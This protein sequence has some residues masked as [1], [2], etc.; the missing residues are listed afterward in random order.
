MLTLARF[1]TSFM[2]IMFFGLFRFGDTSSFLPPTTIVNP[3]STFYSCAVCIFGAFVLAKR[4]IVVSSGIVSPILAFFIILPEA[5]SFS[6]D[7]FG[8]VSVLKKNF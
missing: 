4:T 1:D 8:F 7:V 5:M 2:F 6:T 3:S